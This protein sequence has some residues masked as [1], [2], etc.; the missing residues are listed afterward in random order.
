MST[1]E[2]RTTVAAPAWRSR[3]AAV[4]AAAIGAALVAFIA[5]VAGATMEAANPGQDPIPIGPVNAAF[6][7][8]A[9]GGLG[10]LARALLDRFAPTRARLIWLIGA[11]AAFL[12]ELFPPLLTEATPGTRVALFAM[13]A[14]VA[15]ILFPILGARRDRPNTRS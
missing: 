1:T 2:D 13:H 7:G 15:A 11:S 8:L 14:V 9:A 12:V 6:A 5:S 3:L 4:A 10:W